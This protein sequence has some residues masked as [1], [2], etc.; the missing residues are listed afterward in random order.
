M[1]SSDKSDNV[2][3]A[4]NSGDAFSFLGVEILTW[5]SSLSHDHTLIAVVG[6]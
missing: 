3:G 2:S 4:N 6:T 1:Q 5:E